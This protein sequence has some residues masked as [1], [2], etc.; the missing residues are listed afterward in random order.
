MKTRSVLWLAAAAMLGCA[1]PSFD[2]DRWRQGQG[3]FDEDNPRRE[4]LGDIDRAGVDIGASREEVHGLLGAPD[5]IDAGADVYLLGRAAY[6][7]ETHQ[8]VI[9]YDARG[10]VERLDVVY[11]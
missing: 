1:E 10:I 3:V 2:A 6:A 7:P 5:V 11:L 9:R 4:M 8:L